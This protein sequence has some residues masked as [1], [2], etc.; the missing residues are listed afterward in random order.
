MAETACLPWSCASLRTMSNLLPFNERLERA[1]QLVLRSG[2]FLDLWFYFESQ[3]TRPAIIDTMRR[4]NEFFRFAPHAHFVA[5]VVHTAALFE[6]RKGTINLLSLI[7]EGKEA[8]LFS[9]PVIIEIES[10]LCRATPLAPKV[11]VLRNNLFAHRNASMFYDEAFTKAAVTPSQ[12]REHTEIALKIAN[13]LLPA[14]GMSD[15]FFNERPRNDAEAMLK[16]LALS[17]NAE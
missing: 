14:R 1:A 11:A 10:L 2:I 6:K 15:H 9:T 5:Y 8:Q 17:S 4:F 13:K 3:D 7:K 16:L 12:L